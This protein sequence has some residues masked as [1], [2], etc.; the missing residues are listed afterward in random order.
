MY[1]AIFVL[2]VDNMRGVL[3]T[4]DWGNIKLFHTQVVPWRVRIL[5]NTPVKVYCGSL[6][7]VTWTYLQE[8]LPLPTEYHIEGNY[9]IKLMNLR[10]YHS[11][12]FY[13][14]G[15]YINNDLK[16]TTFKNYIMIHVKKHVDYGEVLPSQLI[17]SEGSNITITCSSIKPVEWI[18][19]HSKYKAKQDSSL[20]LHQITKEQ[21]G[22]Y[23]C[24]GVNHLKHIFQARSVIIVNPHIQIVPSSRLINW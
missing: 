9:S 14:H 15:T 7:P 11:G 20:Y 1:F 23:L 18:S 17:V 2:L 12:T 19:L 3:S 22:P 5:E 16:E 8:H 4:K 6:S 21:S 24:R 13:C 10:E